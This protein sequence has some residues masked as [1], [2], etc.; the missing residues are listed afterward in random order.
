VGYSTTFL[1]LAKFR[2]PLTDEQLGIIQSYIDDES[3]DL[4]LAGR[5]EDGNWIDYDALKWNGAEK[6]YDMVRWLFEIGELL[7]E[8]DPEQGFA[9]GYLEAY[10]ESAGDLWCVKFKDGLAYE[11]GAKLVPDE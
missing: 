2:K 9:D 1:G 5:D 11:V 7:Q 3:A 6:T 10:G 4:E 8:N